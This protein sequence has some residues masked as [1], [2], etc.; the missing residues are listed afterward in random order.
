MPA[1]S[2]RG[3]A[4]HVELKEPLLEGD[5][6]YTLLV[7]PSPTFHDGSGA[8]LPWLQES[9]DPVTKVAWQSWVEIS[10]AT[11]ERLGGLSYGDVVTVSTETGNA[12]LP[13]YPRGGIRD[14]VIAVAMGQGHEVGTYAAGHG[15]NAATLL[16]RGTDEAGGP[17]WLVTR[18]SL[19]TTGR[20]KRLAFLQGSQNQRGRMLGMAVSLH[21]LASGDAHVDDYNEHATPPVSAAAADDHAREG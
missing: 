21:D 14:D 6:D 13:V 16:P 19:A 1:L 3:V 11:A 10:T 4:R 2:V 12:D 7:H 8:N 20:H 9:A 17:A 18:A 15:V 5:G